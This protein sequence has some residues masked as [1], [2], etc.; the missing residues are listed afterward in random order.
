MVHWTWWPVLDIGVSVTDEGVPSEREEE[1]KLME[2][3]SAKL[4]QLIGGFN[5]F[6]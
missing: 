2:A 5:T 1:R 6:L 4:R 3:R